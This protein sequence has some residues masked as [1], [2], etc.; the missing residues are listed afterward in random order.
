M[1][2]G[3]LIDRHVHIRDRGCSS[4]TSLSPADL[5]RSL[6]NS[7]WM[8]AIEMKTSQYSLEIDRITGLV[9]WTIRVEVE[10]VPRGRIHTRDILEVIV[11]CLILTEIEYSEI[12][13]ISCYDESR[14]RD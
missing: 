6:A 9:E 4:D 3:I 14:S 7:R 8:I 11:R 1:E 10:Q 2:I 13:S 5:D 12:S